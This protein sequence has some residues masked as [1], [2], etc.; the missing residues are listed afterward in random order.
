MLIVCAVLTVQ[1]I[2]TGRGSDVVPLIAAI[3]ITIFFV[4]GATIISG[5]YYARLELGEN[6]ITFYGGDYRL[7][8]PWENIRAIGEQRS[9]FRGSI[10]TLELLEPA[11]TDISLKQGNVMRQAIIEKRWKISIGSKSYLRTH[12]SSIPL[13][14]FSKKN[15]ERDEFLQDLRYYIPHLDLRDLDEFYR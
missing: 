12:A 8:T 15:W 10:K 11:S 7:Y 13:L 5:A 3:T 9:P 6:G 4:Y 14:I 1:V 2:G